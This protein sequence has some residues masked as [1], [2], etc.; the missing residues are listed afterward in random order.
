MEAVDVNKLTCWV[1][2]ANKDEVPCGMKRHRRDDLCFLKR[3]K[4]LTINLFVSVN[5]A[6]SQRH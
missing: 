2:C 4:K 5:L 1:L 3:L 6:K